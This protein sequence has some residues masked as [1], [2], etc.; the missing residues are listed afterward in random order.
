MKK[1]QSI[2]ESSI[3]KIGSLIAAGPVFFMQL[4]LARQ[5]TIFDRMWRFWILVRN[6]FYRRSEW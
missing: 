2:L 4:R 1:E 5:L 3:L 6:I